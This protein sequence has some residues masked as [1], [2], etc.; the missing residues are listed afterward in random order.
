MN[1]LKKQIRSKLQPDVNDIISM[2]EHLHSDEYIVLN[3]KKYVF[4]IEQPKQP[5]PYYDCTVLTE[6]KDD[7]KVL[8]TLKTLFG[9]TQNIDVTE[10]SQL[11][12]ADLC[13]Q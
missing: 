5:S 1:R 11:I 2:L 13:C 6:D 4:I 7:I 9:A 3:N 12:A 8:G 10:L